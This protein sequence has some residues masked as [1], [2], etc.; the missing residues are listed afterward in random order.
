MYTFKKYA[1]Q[2]VMS[3]LG[4]METRKARKI[5]YDPGF[6]KEGGRSCGDLG[7]EKVRVCCRLRREKGSSL[8]HM[9]ILDMM[10]ISCV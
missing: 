8:W 6:G 1:R 5:E 10:D 9:D 2:M 4:G 3:A 7:G